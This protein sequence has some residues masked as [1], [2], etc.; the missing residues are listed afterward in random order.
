[1]HLP[2]GGKGERGGGREEEGGGASA[3]FPR[4]S[5]GGFLV[6]KL[7]CGYQYT[8]CKVYLSSH[9]VLELD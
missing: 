1:M 5:G 7:G 3:G 4:T 6:V 8:N 9:F 2:K